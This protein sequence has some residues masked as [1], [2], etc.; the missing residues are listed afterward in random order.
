MEAKRRGF[1]QVGSSGIG[2]EISIG[3]NRNV[4]S[5]YAR[6]R[7]QATPVMAACLKDACWVA[8]IRIPEQPLGQ[9]RVFH[10]L[11]LSSHLVDPV[12][13]APQREG[14]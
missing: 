8:T 12:D 7:S 14:L 2:T 9:S 10:G 3:Q 13:R 1:T 11:D 4:R 5:R 6:N